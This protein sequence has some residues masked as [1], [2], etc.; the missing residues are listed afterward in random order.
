[1]IH[2]HDLPAS[3]SSMDTRNA[4]HEGEDQTNPIVDWFPA[5]AV[6]CAVLAMIV[7]AAF[8]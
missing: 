4:L 2:R 1:M 3:P 8:I 6:R 5:T 7:R